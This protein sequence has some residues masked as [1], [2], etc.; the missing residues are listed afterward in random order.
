VN[1]VICGIMCSTYDIFCNVL[2]GSLGSLCLILLADDEI[3]SL[4]PNSCSC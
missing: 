2:T 3:C 1:A 4:N